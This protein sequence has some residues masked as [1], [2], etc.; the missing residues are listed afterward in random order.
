MKL[1]L[2]TEDT[3]GDIPTTTNIV[4]KLATRDNVMVLIGT[5]L[6]GE[7]G[8]AC[9]VANALGVPVLSPGVGKG[10]VVQAAGPFVFHLV[11]EDC[12][13]T[14]DSLRA[15]IK[16][17]GYKKISIIK[18]QKDPVSKFNGDR[19][20][21]SCWTRWAEACQ[22]GDVHQRRRQLLGAGH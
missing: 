18:D 17:K 11:A 20:S 5:I 13:H 15:A 21:R 16:E 19:A 10:G 4:R 9:P 7:C 2:I 6:S 12:Q 22:R 14:S 1:E 3:R 8:A